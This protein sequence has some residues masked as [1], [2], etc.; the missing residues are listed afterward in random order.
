MSGR[1]SDEREWQAR[2]HGR[3]PGDRWP[4]GEDRSFERADR[5][6]GERDSGV[7]YN[8]PRG[9]ATIGSRGTADWQDRHYQGV[10]PAMRQHDNET[11]YRANPRFPR[12]DERYGGGYGEG[13]RFGSR[14]ADERWAREMRRPAAGGT[15]GDGYDRGYG[16]AGRA[17]GHEPFEDRAREAGEFVRRTGQRVSNW[18]SNVASEDGDTQR[19]EGHRGARGLGPKG[20]ERSDERIS[21]DAHQRLTDDHHLDARDIEVAVSGGEVT[22]SGLVENRH[23]KHHAEHIVEDVSGVRHVQNNLRIKAAGS[24]YGAQA[25]TEGDAAMETSA[26]ATHTTT[27]RS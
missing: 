6:F 11:G 3:G 2:G 7:G 10:S 15:G 18:F 14:E 21:D 19:H 13:H 25:R 24:A 8:R 17:E 5:V 9:E 23:A 1:W 20:Y 27:R 26:N 16:D 4:G 22:L 12:E